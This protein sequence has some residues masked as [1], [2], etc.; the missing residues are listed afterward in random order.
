MRGGVGKKKK[1]K[2]R[3]ERF[4]SPIPQ[5]Q[6]SP[7]QGH[8]HITLHPTS[9][10]PPPQCTHLH[11]IFTPST[12]T[13]SGEPVNRAE[14]ITCLKLA[15][16]SLIVKRT[17]ILLAE[18]GSQPD[19]CHLWHIWSIRHL[20]GQIIVLVSNCLHISVNVH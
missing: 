10:P 8:T 16:K 1:K 5:L 15:K 17:Y 14:Q 12:E 3:I 6:H 11:S 2:P 19:S 13:M 4:S 9:P 18:T 7:A 20:R